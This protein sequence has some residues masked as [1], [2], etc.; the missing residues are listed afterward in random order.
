M[1]VRYTVP[2][3]VTRAAY[4]GNGVT[5]NFSAPFNFFENSD[6]R[7]ILV[8]IATGV[9]TTQVLTTNYTVAGGGGEDGTVTML[10]APPTGTTLVIERAI[11][12][13]QEIDL[14]PNDPFPAEVTEEGFDRAT[15]LAQQTLNRAKQSPKLPPTYDTDGAAIAIPLPEAGQVLVGKSDASGWENSDPVDLGF[16]TLQAALTVDTLA[17]MK[18]L[19]NR[20]EVV[21]VRTGQATGI[22]RWVLASTTTADDALVV[23]PTSGD[24]GRYKR[25]YDGAL[26]VDWWGASTDAATIAAR[27]VQ[28]YTY[29]PSGETHPTLFIPRLCVAPDDGTVHGIRIFAD[30]HPD[31]LVAQSSMIYNS[32]EFAVYGSAAEGQGTGTNATANVELTTGNAADSTWVNKPFYLSN[33]KFR[34]ATVVDATHITVKNYDGSAYSGFSGDVTATWHFTYVSGSGTVNTNGTAVTWVSGQKF[35]PGPSTITI[36]GVDY[37]FTYVSA[38]TATLGSSAGVQSA[39]VYSWWYNADDQLAAVKVNK[40]KSNGEEVLDIKAHYWGYRIGSNYSSPGINYPIRLNTGDSAGTRWDQIEI[41]PD[42]TVYLGGPSWDLNANVAG[43]FAVKV[44]TKFTSVNWLEFEG[45]A[46]GSSPT[47]SAKGAGTNLDVLLVPK[48]TGVTKS[49]GVALATVAQ[50][51]SVLFGQMLPEALAAG[52]TKYMTSI[53]NTADSLIW[54]PMPIAGTLSNF[55]VFTNNTAPGASQ[56]YTCT[57]VKVVAGTPGDTALV[58]TISGASATNAADTVNT[59]TFAANDLFYVKVVCSAGAAGA[60]IGWSAQFIPTA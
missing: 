42:G 17:D 45:G 13:T 8:T 15:M 52:T 59:A 34:V 51:K 4:S 28:G 39:A 20:P 18:A 24:A 46:S 6:L 40:I 22:W 2:S 33:L 16:T 11:P 49:G 32:T 44:I 10:V 1:K 14:E 38:T 21:I 58:A 37:T 43:W 9:E 29:R 23:T 48:G 60:T 25:I 53:G 31:F 36:A 50:V 19:T 27:T 57:V 55:R 12:Y 5:V 54:V 26:N 41:K 47:L 7:V 35:I 56:T 30:A 3:A